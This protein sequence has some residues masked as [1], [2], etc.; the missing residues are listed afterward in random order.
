MATQK[1]VLIEF[2]SYFFG[3]QK[4]GS[5]SSIDYKLIDLD[6]IFTNTDDDYQALLR[7]NFSEFHR[8]IHGFVKH[9]VTET[10]QTEY[11][12]LLEQQLIRDN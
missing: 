10:N 1:N 7:L 6:H 4:I 9:F 5:K 8:A 11:Y 2:D 12:Q 3:T